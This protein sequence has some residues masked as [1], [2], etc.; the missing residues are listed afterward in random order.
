VKSSTNRY[1]ARVASLVGEND[2][3]RAVQ[4]FVKKSRGETASLENVARKLGVEEVI[5][6]R[7]PFEGGIFRERGRLVIR[8]NAASSFA[9][10]RFTLA[11][12]IAHL[13]LGTVPGR[14]STSHGDPALERACD[15]VA[16]ELLMPAEETVPFIKEL[17]SPCPRK[18]RL[19]ASKYG[20]SQHVAAIRVRDDFRLWRCCIGRWEWHGTVKTKWFVGERRWD[21]AE[22]NTHSLQLAIDATEP[23]RTTELWPRGGFNEQVWLNL[24]NTGS[25]PKTGAKHVLGLVAFVN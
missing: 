12:E 8:L 3:A 9:R 17:G 15:F 25:D 18:L 22:P 1:L 19:I 13:L 5:E 4:V 20:V 21:V 6:E 7:L 11:H 14:R 16:A 23:V 10:K 24:L 2:T